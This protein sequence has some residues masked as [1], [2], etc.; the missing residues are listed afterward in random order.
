MSQQQTSKTTTHR[1]L[2][3]QLEEIKRPVIVEV[4]PVKPVVQLRPYQ[5]E[6]V[7]AT[8][9]AWQN[10]YRS[11]LVQLPTGCGKSVLFSEIMRR[12]CSYED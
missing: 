6:A 1:D 11:V 2:F 7:D 4:E 12:V 10:G 9:A 5:Q 3:S 8:F